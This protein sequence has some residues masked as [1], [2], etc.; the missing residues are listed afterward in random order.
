MFKPDSPK[1]IGQNDN[2]LAMS[3]N[4]NMRRSLMLSNLNRAEIPSN[5]D[6]NNTSIY[7]QKL[8]RMKQTE[9]SI[10]RKLREVTGRNSAR[11]SYLI[12]S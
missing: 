12:D 4:V 1:N 2:N 5:V 11:D 9:A 6:N 10:T 7:A 8:N 3:E